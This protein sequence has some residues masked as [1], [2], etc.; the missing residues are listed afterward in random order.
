MKDI[1]QIG[2]E[3]KFSWNPKII[4][5]LDGILLDG[6]VDVLLHCSTHDTLEIFTCE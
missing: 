6:G 1:Y 3:G 2:G 5:S 4:F